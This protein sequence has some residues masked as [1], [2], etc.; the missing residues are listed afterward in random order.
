MHRDLIAAIIITV[1]VVSYYAAVKWIDG[2][3]SYTGEEFRSVEEIT[4]P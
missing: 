4:H 2:R 3:P 1:V